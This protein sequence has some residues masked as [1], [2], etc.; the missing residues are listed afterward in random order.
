MQNMLQMARSIIKQQLPKKSV[1]ALRK[2]IEIVFVAC[3]IGSIE[4]IA[5][6]LYT[7]SNAELRSFPNS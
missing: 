3:M 7:R 6:M 1:L 4:N 2:Y 5:R